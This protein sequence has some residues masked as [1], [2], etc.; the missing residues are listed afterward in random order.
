VT[1]PAR[2]VFLGTGEFAVPIVRALRDAPELELLAV[3]TAPPRPAKRGLALVAS[4]VGIW[5]AANEVPQLTPR[6]LRDAEAFEQLRALEPA[7]L[8]L[9]DY[10]RLVP[11]DWL[12][13]PAHGAL[14]VHPSLLPRFRGASPIPAAILAG[15]SETGVTLMRMDEG[16]DTGPIVAQVRVPLRGDEVAPELEA[17]LAEDGA[18][19]LRENLAGWLDGSV[20]AQPQLAEGATLTRPLARE[21]GRLDPSWPAMAL[22]RHVRAYQPWPGSFLE[23]GGDRLVVWRASAAEARRGEGSAGLG[24]LV[25]VGRGLGMITSDGVL[26]LDEVQRAGAR[27]MTS[28]ELV[29]GQPNWIG[30]S[31]DANPLPSPR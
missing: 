13:L 5:A 6:K 17:R 31:S 2:T 30:R 11:G 19:V 29:R 8:V 27:R 22:E 20:I 21:E 14:N 26:S 25:L 10:G 18:R 4:P 7:L 3:I 12:A 23:A 16:L 9:A 24:D 1:E 15:D 28:E